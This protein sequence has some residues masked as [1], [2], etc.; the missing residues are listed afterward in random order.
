MDRQSTL[1]LVEHHGRPLAA[2]APERDY[3]ATAFELDGSC[4]AP[5]VQPGTEP[6]L[7]YSH[8]L[9]EVIGGNEK[10]AE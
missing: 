2:S 4:L 9:P 8:S 3:D 7:F 10:L 5:E 1:E 6:Q